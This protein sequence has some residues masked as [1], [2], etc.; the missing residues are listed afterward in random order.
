[1]SVLAHVISKSSIQNEPAA[2]LALHHILISSSKKMSRALIRMMPEG[3]IDHSLKPSRIEVELEHESNRPDLTLYD[4]EGRV[5]IFIE[6]KF[7]AGLTDRQPVAY[8]NSLS[9]DYSTALLFIVPDQRKLA[10]W[11]LLKRKC[12]EENLKLETQSAEGGVFWARLGCKSM[13]VT[14]WKY[15]LDWLQE[16]GDPEEELGLDIRQLRGLIKKMDS[17]EAFLPIHF[18]E[19]SDQSIALRLVNYANLISECLEHI[20]EL[21]FI[22]INGKFS[23]SLKQGQYYSGQ[24]IRLHGRFLMWFGIDFGIWSESGITPFWICPVNNNDEKSNDWVNGKC[25]RESICH[26][27][28]DECINTEYQL[29]YIPIRLKTGVEKEDILTDIMNQISYIADTLKNH[30]PNS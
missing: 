2:T 12:K 9:D 22:D 6:N 11:N 4:V 29:P 16:A 27:F 1:M 5:R 15:V 7:W 10:I 21:D 13:L 18:S 20:S 3:S 17:S 23:S 25:D 24:R 30:Y 14:S 26:I 19:I 28:S 8:L